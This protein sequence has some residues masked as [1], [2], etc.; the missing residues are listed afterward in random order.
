VCFQNDFE[1]KKKKKLAS[2]EKR[3]SPPLLQKERKRKEK[4]KIII[5]I[6]ELIL[7]FRWQGVHMKFGWT[8][9]QGK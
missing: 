9:R 8:L 3:K 1:K 5:K 4:R 6:P 2:K 7:D